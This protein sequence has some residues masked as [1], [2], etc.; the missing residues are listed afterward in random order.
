MVAEASMG[1]PRVI[2]VLCDMALVYGFST[3]SDKI[4]GELVQEVIEDKRSF[5]IFPINGHASK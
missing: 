1:V 4:T 3:G 5:G 2:N